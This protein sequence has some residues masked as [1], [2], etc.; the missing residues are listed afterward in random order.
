MVGDPVHGIIQIY[1]P[2]ILTLH[3]SLSPNIIQALLLHYVDFFTPVNTLPP[4]RNI[5][6]WIPLLSATSGVCPYCYR[7]AQKAE[8]ERQM[9]EMLL[10]G[11]KQPSL[12]LFSSPTLL[13]AKDN[14]SLCFC[15]DYKVVNSLTINDRFLLPL[16]MTYW[17]NYIVQ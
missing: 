14:D 9:D 5:N 11:I 16:L 4:R 7:H 15:V 13:V 3:A 1:N 17:W 8:L 10:A 12:S 6:P 2:F